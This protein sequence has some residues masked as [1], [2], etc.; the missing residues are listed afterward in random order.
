MSPRALPGPLGVLR[1]TERVL[2]DRPRPGDAPCSIPALSREFG[3]LPALLAVGS[4]RDAVLSGKDAPGPCVGNPFLYGHRK[5]GLGERHSF[6]FCASLGG[7]FAAAFL[8]P[9]PPPGADAGAVRRCFSLLHSLGH[10][11]IPV[12][13]LP[14]PPSLPPPAGCHP[15]SGSRAV[16]LSCDFAWARNVGPQ[17]FWSRVGVVL[18]LAR[19]PTTPCVSRS[20]FCLFSCVRCCMGREKPEPLQTE[21]E[22]GG[23]SYSRGAEISMSS[24]GCVRGAVSYGHAVQN[25]GS[26]LGIV[27]G[28]P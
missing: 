10:C 1:P 26:T 14:P 4:G 18:S 22:G 12:C 2:S 8:C 6:G 27:P 23:G 21:G 3:L 25:P 11:W 7:L 13:S 28:G 19:H 17:L 9:S 15:P 5:R 24:I 16:Q 20:G